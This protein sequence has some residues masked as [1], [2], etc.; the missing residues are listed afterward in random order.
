MH[1]QFNLQPEIENH[2]IFT[3]SHTLNNNSKNNLQR[4]QGKYFLYLQ[5]S[6]SECTFMI[7]LISIQIDDTAV[8]G[9]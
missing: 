3:P 6:D 7:Y 9:V 8:R 1:F 4:E 5:F 2:N